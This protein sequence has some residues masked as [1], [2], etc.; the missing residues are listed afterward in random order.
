MRNGQ[1]FEMPAREVALYEFDDFRLDTKNQQL[2]KNGEP[3]PLTHK[4]FQILLIL[5]RNSGETVEKEHIYQQLWGDSFV[6]DANLTQHIYVLRKALGPNPAGESYIETV[7]RLGYRFGADVREI[8]QSTILPVAG[9]AQD[10]PT[11]TRE[12][13]LPPEETRKLK[14]LHLSLVGPFQNEAMHHDPAADHAI[15]PGSDRRRIGIAVAVIAVISLLA[16]AAYFVYRPRQPAAGNAPVKS[17]AVLPFKPIGDE[18]KNEKMGLGMADAIIT[19]LSKL[20]QIPVRPTSAIAGYT[21]QPAPDSRAAGKAMGV[22]TVLEGSMQLDSGRVRVSVRLIDVPNGNNIWAENFDENYTNIFNV[23]DSISAKVVQA[24]ELNLTDQQREVISKRSTTNTDAYQA[25]QM[26]IYYGSKRN[27]ESLENAATYF[28]K[29]TELDPNYAEAYAMLADTY[30]MQGYYGYYPVPE[31]APK[32]NKAAAKAIELNSEIAEAYVALAFM[33]GRYPNGRVAAKQLLEKA[34]ELSPYNST[35]HV[36]YGWVLLRDGTDK[37]VKEMRL[38][39]EYDPL[40]P[41]TNGALC[42]ALIFDNKISEAI[43]YCEKSVELAREIPTSRV[44]LADAYYLS[45][46]PDDA[47]AQINSRIAETE[48]VERAGAEGS[49]AFYYAK[50]GRRSEAEEIF[51][52][53]KPL[54]D[55]QPSVLNDLIL[56]S[57]A[58]DRPDEGYGYFRQAVD[59]RLLTSVMYEYHPIWEQVRADKRTLDYIYEVRGITPPPA[60]PAS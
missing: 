34:I 23:Q 26:G 9:R 3:I 45:G 8:K 25:Y 52:R 59:K 11:E 54:I 43:P 33:Q 21:D 47:L 58:L 31:V 48:G 27:R 55:E 42:N 51:N 36:R 13:V 6:E 40:S 53:L 41:L 44:L 12:E 18:S 7:S 38:A 10:A 4:A 39:Q 16:L 28:Q 57:Y 15:S 30:N 19:R 20:R 17:V 1:A 60:S 29:A 46:R 5:V 35:A 56:I 50:L 22:D 49:L 37:T 14:D 24:L 32:A 2:S